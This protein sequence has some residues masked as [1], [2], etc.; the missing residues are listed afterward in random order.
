[1]TL[2]EDERRCHA[3]G[4]A[5]PPGGLRLGTEGGGAEYEWFCKNIVACVDRCGQQVRKEDRRP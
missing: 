4:M 5:D 1:M 2:D 3:C